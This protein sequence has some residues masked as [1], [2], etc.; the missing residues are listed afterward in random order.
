MKI[1]KAPLCRPDLSFTFH[2]S[3][4]AC[5]AALLTLG[6]APLTRAQTSDAASATNTVSEADKVW[7][8]TAKLL[9]PPM[10]PAEWQMQR[11]TQEEIQQFRDDKGKLA[12]EAAEKAKDFYTRFPNHAKAAEARTKEYDMLQ[13]ALQLGNTSV[14]AALEARE[15]ERLK[16]PSLSEDERFKLR[17]EAEQRGVMARIQSEG[18]S[19]AIPAL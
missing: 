11:P 7:K 3:R 2:V 4:V 12:A 10:P 15:Q 16:D 14:T 1:P 18:Q 6:S 8:E 19:A 9:V 17:F 5:L 13:T